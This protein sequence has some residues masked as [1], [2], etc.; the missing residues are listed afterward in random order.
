MEKSRP[1]HLK[2]KKGS[3]L[4]TIVILCL[5]AVMIFSGYKIFS[6]LW[7]YKEGADSY[8]KIAQ[9]A[10]SVLDND[11]STSDAAAEEKEIL[12]ISVDFA[13]LQELCPDVIAWI[14]SPGTEINY[15][16]VQGEDNE[17]YLHH[18]TDGTY[19]SAGSIF[20]DYRCEAFTAGNTIL[21][22]HHM[23]DGSMFQSL[24]NYKEQSYYDAHNVLYILTP[25]K[26]YMFLPLCGAV[27]GADDPIYMTADGVS[28]DLTASLN[29][30]MEKS[31][32]QSR[33]QYETGDRLVTLSTCTYEYNDAR[34]VVVG[35][36]AE[37]EQ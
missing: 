16:V 19:N 11:I 10:V 32:F 2:K 12:P 7:G 27:I 34:Y 14:Y 20:A 30:L 1:K 22:G 26:N 18:L 29:D 17:Y 31:T 15:P 21:Y 13:K 9:S 23:K 33:A 3:P 35:R 8:T 25:E 24:V 4:L 37:L 36:L 28:G 6:I 5:A